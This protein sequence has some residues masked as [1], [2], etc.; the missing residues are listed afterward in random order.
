MVTGMSLS[1]TISEHELGSD[2]KKSHTRVLMACSL[3]DHE[4]GHGH[5]HE[6]HRL[7]AGQ[8]MRMIMIMGMTMLPIKVMVAQAAWE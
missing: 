4:R 1:T 6:R 3:H 7:N 8:A 2:L 5:G